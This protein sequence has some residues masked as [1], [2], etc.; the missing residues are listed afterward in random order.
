MDK[1]IEKE[2]YLLKKVYKYKL[3]RQQYLTLKGQLR[4]GNIDGFR[5][6]L[7]IIL[8]RKYTK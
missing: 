6:G 2:W 1:G 8:K 4:S 3:S 7:F 5:K